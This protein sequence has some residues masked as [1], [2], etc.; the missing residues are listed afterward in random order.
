M[1][2][3]T[4]IF[5]LSL[6][7]LAWS[8]SEQTQFKVTHGPLLGRPGSDTMSIW[9]R[10]NI[11]GNVSVTYGTDP[12]VLD[13]QSAPF[14]TS[15]EHDN[16]AVI[17][18][19]HLEPDTTYY[20]RT[21]TGRGGSF[22]TFPDPDDYRNA[23]H[24]P[25]GLFNFQ[26]HATSCINQNSGAGP[27]PDLP[28]YDVLNRDWRGKVLFG[29]NNGDFIYEEDR[30]LTLEA[31][32]QQVRIKPED[33]PE[34]LKIAP[35][36]V[37]VWENYKTYL[38]RG[39]NLMEWHQNVP[40]FYTYDDHEL[41]N[42]IYGTAEIGFVNRRAVFRDQGV[43]AWHDYVGWANPMAHTAPTH[44]GRGQFKAGSDILYD[45]K[46]N[47]TAM[48]MK[49][50]STLHVHW[51]RPDDGVLDMALDQVPGD[52]NS[53]VYEVV[54]VLD[55]H[56]LKI[57]PPAKAT[58]TAAYSIGR[59][60]YGSFKV[61]NCEYFLLQTRPHRTLHDVSNPWKKDAVILGPEQ[62]AW[63]K[64]GIAKSTADFIFMV[65]S[66]DFTIPHVGSGGGADKNT[67]PKD[68]AWTVFLQEREE[69]IEY[70]T[71]H[72]PQQFFV[73]T[74]DLH[75]SFAIQITGN[76]W[77]FAAGPG[78]SVNHVPLADEGGRPI[79]GKFK[80][81]PRE[82]DIKWSTY[83]YGDVPRLDRFY[84]TF[85]IAQVNNVFNNPIQR[86]GT[87]WVAFPKP[88]IIFKYYDGYTGELLYAQ[89]V[90]AR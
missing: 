14:A 28:S 49:D 90:H 72:A 26:F 12:L 44:F 86:G 29:I 75:N 66:V 31:W 65:S 22:R 60:S 78:N 55:A 57:N 89:P 27:G 46:A 69:L 38:S 58:N 17:T 41:Q 62:F 56:R 71:K 1:K 7:S 67:Y 37:G 64:E 48:D 59:R 24:N 79:N 88:Y 32:Q 42:D 63:L 3:T 73:I 82:V 19:N 11:P 35:S 83:T 54:E 50:Y 30:D 10:T 8:Q 33:T 61:G 13:Q 18:L 52:P 43:K 23:E 40:N 45:P 77:E 5:L 70:C 20:Y 76:M 15:L 53:A 80:Y 51:G 6:S 85:C 39:L 21:D 74:G 68:E 25:E 87:R 81:G 36:I 2:K 47:F 34:V 4:L 9:V 16:T 84:P